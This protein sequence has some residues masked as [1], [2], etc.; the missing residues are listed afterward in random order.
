[1]GDAA[2]LRHRLPVLQLQQ[3]QWLRRAVPAARCQS[4]IGEKRRRSW[5]TR[6][7][8]P[9]P[10]TL[11][12]PRVSRS[13]C[14][15]RRAGVPLLRMPMLDGGNGAESYGCGKR[16]LRH[17]GQACLRGSLAD[18]PLLPRPPSL[19]RGGSPRE[20][21]VVAGAFFRGARLGCCAGRRE[22][23]GST[24]STPPSPG[25]SL[26][27]AARCRFAVCVGCAPGRYGAGAAR[28]LRI[29]VIR[30]SR[31]RRANA[32]GCRNKEHTRK[33]RRWHMRCVLFLS[34]TARPLTSPLARLLCARRHGVRMMTRSGRGSAAPPR[35]AAG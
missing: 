24:S 27:G 20:R 21:A 23:A 5:R 35:C 32:L 2:P 6:T 17:T 34:H 16:P 12:L 15:P 26:S 25:T 30:G 10:C 29:A 19:P 28:R 9:G 33:G 4:S 18:S 31:R 1:M 14:R 13:G 8:A 3:E 7:A 22:Q 11:L